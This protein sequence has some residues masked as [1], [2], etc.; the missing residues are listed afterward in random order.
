MLMLQVL[1]VVWHKQ[2]L[3]T[4][5]SS[6]WCAQYVRAVAAVRHSVTVVVGGQ[7]AVK[8]QQRY[9]LWLLSAAML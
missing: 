6:F 5:C 4:H 8:G 9:A 2:Q 3:C 1:V 7:A